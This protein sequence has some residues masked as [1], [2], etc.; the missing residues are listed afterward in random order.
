MG[1]SSTILG[2]SRPGDDRTSG[3]TIS[4]ASRISAGQ[5]PTRLIGRMRGVDRE[6]D[7]ER[8]LEGWRPLGGLGGEGARFVLGGRLGQGSQGVVF[9]LRDRD[10]QRVVALKT[11]N[12]RELDDDE[13]ARFLHEVQITAQLEHPGVVPVHDVGVLTDGTLFYTMKR[14]EGMV[15]TDWLAGRSGR[16]EHRFEIIQLFL[17]VCDTMAFAHSRGVV[18]RDLKPRNIMVGTY[19]EVLVMDWGL[20]KVLGSVED[21]SEP[22]SATTALISDVRLTGATDHETLAGTAVGTPAY[23][24]PEQ[25]SGQLRNVDHRSD[26]YGLGVLLYEMFS[27]ASPYVRGDL[28]RTIAQVTEGRWTPV[29]RQPACQDLP[30]RLAAIVHKAMAHRREDR[31]QHVTELSGDLRAFL[32]GESVSAYRETLADTMARVV[33]RHRRSIIWS[34][35]AFAAIIGAASTVWWIRQIRDQRVVAALRS[36]AA[37]AVARG[38]WVRA[39]KANEGIVIYQPGDREAQAASIRFDERARAE[40]D[41]LIR[42]TTQAELVRK[43]HARADELRTAAAA[44]AARGGVTD[45]AEAVQLTKQAQALHPDA[46]GLAADYERWVA[47]LS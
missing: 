22:G 33:H 6:S 41:R 27:G 34:A 4:T 38:D 18:H 9:A 10:T 3:D 1:N 32:A 11:L 7:L 47:E 8:A 36:E 15:L 13:V 26:I 12:G 24:S 19:G 21:A 23:M 42:E 31:Y 44:A 14:V 17:K 20:A 40:S 29:D 35:A 46:P 37:D 2:S 30:R 25:A 45:L 43:A 16:T 5:V 28:R 39:R